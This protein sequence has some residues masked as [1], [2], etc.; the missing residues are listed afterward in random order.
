MA[1]T[2]SILRFEFV[3]AENRRE[4]SDGYG[5]GTLFLND[6][7]LWYSTSQDA[8]TPVKWT[9]VDFLEH[10]AEIW[11]ALIVEQSYPFDWLNKQVIHPGEMWDQAELRWSLQGD[12]VADEEEP[13][14]YAFHNR[15]NLSAGWKGIGLPALYWLRIGK[16][17][18]LA[19]E[20]GQAIRADFNQCKCSLEAICEQ[21]VDAFA[22]S[23]NARVIAATEA[24]R[25]RQ[26]SLRN[27][28]FKFATGLGDAELA[29]LEQGRPQAEYWEI[30]QLANFEDAA[31]NDSELLA[32]ARM[33]KGILCPT[34]ISALIETVRRIPKVNTPGLDDLGLRASKFLASSD[35]LYAH[36]SGYGLAQW[37]R[38]QLGLEARVQ[39]DVLAYLHSLDVSIVSEKF[40]SDH[41][42]ALACWGRHGPSIIIN[43]ERAFAHDTNR[44]RM[45]LAHELC[46]FLVDRGSALP[47]AE[48]LGGSVDAYVERR[49][50]AFA[51]ELLLP[52]A[53]VILA[54]EAGH[55]TLQDQLRFLG[56]RFGVSKAV[57][58]AQ[59]F[60]S[61]LF[62]A[63]RAQEREYV[64]TRL[65]RF[66]EL[67]FP[68]EKI[69]SGIV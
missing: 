3:P 11:D 17:V 26:N 22:G 51:A 52:R 60:N 68:D 16:S 19:P 21:L 5:A 4:R 32:A 35:Q 6:H 36:E 53:G 24:W 31:E 10:M 13:I 2:D 29:A 41:I 18:W 1:D 43:L 39:F 15:H 64:K 62:P 47:V 38:A 66:A 28:F 14:L 45:S 25:A 7:P 50:Y 34:S 33:T 65:Q 49:A 48:V 61:P 59:V 23:D 55:T 27:S 20:G 42:D 37:L 12:T 56:N 69:Y 30:S 44:L 46:H 57:V 67:K 9:W 8:P 54:G 63:L 58:C 40:G